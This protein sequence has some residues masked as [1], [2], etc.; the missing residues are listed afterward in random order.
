MRKLLSLLLVILAA[1]ACRELDTPKQPNNNKKPTLT[2]SAE[3]T[4]VWEF[5]PAPGQFINEGY[6]AHTQA[7]ANA[8]ATQRLAKG[9][10]VSLGGFGGYIVVG[11]DHSIQNRSYLNP[12][13]R[14]EPAYF[15]F[16]I[17][18]NEFSGS[19]EP[20][21]V[22]V[23]QD[24][25]GNGKP[26]DTWYELKGSDTF[27]DATNRNYQ[28][29][30]FRPSAPKEPVR[31][32]D[33]T[34]KEGTIDRIEAYHPQDYYYP[35]W[36]KADKY[37][38]KGTLLHTTLG[39]DER[40]Y[41]VYKDFDWG[42]VDNFAKEGRFTVTLKDGAKPTCA[43]FKISDAIDER[44]NSVK[45]DYI[46]FVKVQSGANAKNVLMGENSTEVCRFVDIQLL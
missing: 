27:A 39:K 41:F 16:A 28:V 37:T 40:G 12:E 38:L 36:V 3:S 14:D 26:D 6:A 17:A 19:S 21:I 10:H 25:N 23:M 32:Q 18:G 20:G 43:H 29:T 44:G 42:Y 4:K 15:D 9:E 31:W 45:L 5:L 1:T 11:F 35:L 46:D 33:N 13:K 30:Y 24:S 2:S 7:E 8:Y 22:F 34:G